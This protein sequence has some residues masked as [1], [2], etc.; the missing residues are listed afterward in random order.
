M[1][2]SEDRAIPVCH[3][4]VVSISQ[5]IGAGFSTQAFLTTLELFE[6]TEVSRDLGCHDLVV[7]AVGDIDNTVAWR[8]VEEERER[9][10]RKGRD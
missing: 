2:R 8:T 6:E 5:A 7:K 9:E 4:Q 1:R 10:K 3:H